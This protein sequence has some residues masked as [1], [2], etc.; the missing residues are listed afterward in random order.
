MSIEA[1]ASNLYGSFLYEG[2]YRPR[3]GLTFAERSNWGLH[4][5][6]ARH[7]IANAHACLRS[8]SRTI[9]HRVSMPPQRLCHGFGRIPEVGQLHSCRR[10]ARRFRMVSATVS[11]VRHAMY[12]G[13]RTSTKRPGL[14]RWHRLRVCVGSIKASCLVAGGRAF[15]TGFMPS[16]GKTM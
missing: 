4:G 7:I 2:C 15:V 8:T 6:L 10:K 1:V 12:C 13:A 3:G 14:A 11:L 9:G 5:A 16:K